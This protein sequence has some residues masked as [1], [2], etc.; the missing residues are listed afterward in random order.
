ME[1]LIKKGHRVVLLTSCKRGFLHE[2][3]ASKGV[4]TRA[5]DDEEGKF[6][7]YR[8]N[9]KRLRAA[10]AEF[11]IDIVI[12]HQ[13]VT[14]LI[15]GLVRTMK[16]FKLVYV[17]HNSDEDYLLNRAKAKWYNRLVNSLTPVKLAP[18]STVENF[19][20]D[21]ERVSTKIYR[22]NYG[23]NFDQ[24]DAP[25]ASE[26]ERIREKFPTQ[27][28][29]LSM[30]RLVPSKR[31]AVMFSIVKRLVESG[32]DCNLLCLGS[33]NL[34]DELTNLVME[35]EMERHIFLLGRQ[36][37]IF[38]WISATDV[39]LHL[40][41]TEASNSAVKEVGLCRK[42]V[43]VCKGV[44]DFEDYITHGE[45]GF[46]VDKAY[47]DDEAFLLLTALAKGEVNKEQIGNKLFE[48]VTSTFDINNIAGQYEQLLN[49]LV[50]N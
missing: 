43:I 21:N 33:G 12:A 24:Y 10:I 2:Y 11:D 25:V 40:S 50:N 31:H 32:I 30:A 17:R 1:M 27:L 36:E 7:F 47:P 15:A 22:I 9:I 26:V 3:M 38:D 14:A 6:S 18:S 46:L 19:W 34:R 4:I 48:T 23:Y 16:K 5:V 42:P 49:D 28:R 37:N 41:A 13:Q 20:K 35:L 39:F 45:N 8:S 29:I 44:G